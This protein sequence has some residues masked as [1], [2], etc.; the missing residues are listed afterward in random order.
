MSVYE[1][2]ASDRQVPSVEAAPHRGHFLS[3]GHLYL[4]GAVLA[5]HLPFQ[6]P[7]R[8]QP[9]AE[10]ELHLQALGAPLLRLDVCGYTSQRAYWSVL[11]ISKPM[12]FIDVATKVD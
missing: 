2:G 12:Y 11:F 1:P 4:F 10:K 5:V 6:V 9:P 8:S 7:L 3:P